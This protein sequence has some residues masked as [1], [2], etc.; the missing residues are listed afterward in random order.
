MKRDADFLISRYNAY[1]PACGYAA[2]IIHGAPLDVDFGTPAAASAAA[3]L[4]LQSIAVAGTQSTLL[5]TTADAKFGKNITV[6][7]SGAATSAVTINGWDYLGQP[8]S[9]T[10]TLNGATPVVGVKC[11]KFLRNVVFAA[12]GGTT[13]NVGYGSKLGLPYV[14]HRVLGETADGVTAAAGTLVSGIR[15]DPQTATTVDPRGSYTPT[16]TADGIKRLRAVVLVDNFV[17]A[18][19]NGGLYGIRHFST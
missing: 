15:T 2:D 3:I 1:V 9:E 19:G 12:T 10:F 8:M 16:T 4:S 6:V 13:I 14:T 5:S 17:N 11:F 7:A 18:A